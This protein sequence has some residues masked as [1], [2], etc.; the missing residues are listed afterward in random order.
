VKKGV[1]RVPRVQQ[2]DIITNAAPLKHLKSP[3]K[4]QIL[5]RYTRYYTYKTTHLQKPCCCIVPEPLLSPPPVV[6]RRGMEAE[7]RELIAGVDR[8]LGVG[9]GLEKD[10][11]MM[12]G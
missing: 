5:F 4:W 6:D 10:G 8:D 7:S 11:N 9:V 3:N 1:F 12:E 2:L